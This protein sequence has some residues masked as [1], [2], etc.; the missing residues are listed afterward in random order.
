MN[1]RLV[2]PHDPVLWARRDR[3]VRLYV[4]DHRIDIAPASNVCRSL[5]EYREAVAAGDQEVA[6]GHAQPIGR[7]DSALAD[8]EGR[9]IH[10][11]TGGSGLR[12]AVRA[13]LR[14]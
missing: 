11:V 10:T 12:V 13:D 6:R 7:R 9:G 5:L 14:P 3:R 1:T 4:G 8:H 2:R